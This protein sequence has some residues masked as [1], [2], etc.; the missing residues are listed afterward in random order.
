VSVCVCVFVCVCVCVCVCVQPHVERRTAVCS[1]AAGKT[2]GCTC[3]LRCRAS[4]PQTCPA[5]PPRLCAHRHQVAKYDLTITAPSGSKLYDV[6]AESEVSFH[7]VPVESGAHRFCI[8]CACACMR[9]LPCT[10]AP[11]AAA[12]VTAPSRAV[13]DGC[14]APRLAPLICQPPCLR[15]PPPNTHTHHTHTCTAPAVCQVCARR[16]AQQ[17][18]HIAR[19]AVEHGGRLLGGPRQD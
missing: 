16:L 2:T 10:R 6:H 5:P 12:L 14:M 13:H 18:R 15:P 11:A 4:V 9:T 8:K 17:R 3:H 7:L 1:A 19:R